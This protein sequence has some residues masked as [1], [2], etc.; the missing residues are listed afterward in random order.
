[1]ARSMAPEVVAI[2]PSA[3]PSPRGDRLIGDLAD[4]QHGVV[5]YDQLVALGYTRQMIRTRVA[6]GR[7]HPLHYAVYALGRRRL[8]PNGHRMAAVLAAGDGAL[9]SHRSAG[10][11]WGMLQSGGTKIE[12]T[13]TGTGRAKR[14]GLTIHRTR[15]LHPADR[16]AH[17]N[18][19]ATSPARTLLDLAGVLDRDR[20]LRAIENADRLGIFDLRQ[21]E[22][23]IK[24]RPNAKGSQ[25][26]SDL[27][28]TY[29]DPPPTRSELEREFLDLVGRAG[30]PEPHTNVL[31]AGLEVD[32][33]WPKF[34][35]VVELDGRA[36]H[37]SPRAFETDRIRDATLQRHDCK[38]LRVTPRRLR[39]QPEAVLTDVRALGRFA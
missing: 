18:I 4:R 25:T 29:R 11:L 16:S 21:L 15:A 35:L 19:P 24:R 1:M 38:V 33:Y 14:P 34:R 36:Y 5:A 13:V 27:L 3:E 7:L 32:F 17:Q 30:L 6:T 26:L 2:E 9:L 37:S 8:T 10:A 23:A 39:R 31:V 22:K 28:A 20:L 12:V